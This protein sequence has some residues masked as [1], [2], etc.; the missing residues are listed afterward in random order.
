MKPLRTLLAL[1]ALTCVAL[2]GEARTIRADEVIPNSNT[3]AAIAYSPATGNYGY[4]YNYGTRFDAEAAALRHCKAEDARIVTWVNNG[5]CA[6]ALGDDKSTWGVG[7]RYGPGASNADAKRTAL[8]E[9][10]KRTTNARIVL[11]V[12]S[13]NVAPEKP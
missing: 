8:N 10:A 12:S 6:L 5:F 2:L 9:C 11:C 7:W 1:F 13:A 4:G 3:Y